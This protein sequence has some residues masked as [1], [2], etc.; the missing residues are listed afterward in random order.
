MTIR[1]AVAKAILNEIE[2]CSAS[3]LLLFSQEQDR[4]VLRQFLDIGILRDEE[5]ERVLSVAVVNDARAA[6]KYMERTK[7]YA[8][9]AGAYPEHLAYAIE[10]N[11]L[12]QRELMV[13]TRCL[14][15]EKSLEEFCKHYSSSNLIANLKKKLLEE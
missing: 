9:H 14:D 13:I 12:N 11:K 1:Q 3:S 15:H 7:T 8:D 4:R 2:T 6:V 5:L 10:N